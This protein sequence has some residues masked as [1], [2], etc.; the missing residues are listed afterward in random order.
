MRRRLARALFPP[1]LR[2]TL[3]VKLPW[4]DV[5]RVLLIAAASAL[6]G[7][8]AHDVFY[9]ERIGAYHADE[10]REIVA[11]ETAGAY[12]MAEAAAHQSARVAEARV[13]EQLARAGV[14]PREKTPAELAYHADKEARRARQEAQKTA[15]K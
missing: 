6:L 10:A 5:G 2:N 1:I 7:A 13:N 15:P 3:S 12:Q 11:D 8:G 14:K 9:S 4:M